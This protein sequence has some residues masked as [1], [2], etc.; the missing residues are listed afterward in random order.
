MT[1]QSNT[2]KVVQTSEHL[3]ILVAG[4]T[5][6]GFQGVDEFG[7]LH[8]FSFQELEEDG[9]KEDEDLGRRDISAEFS[10]QT[11]NGGAPHKI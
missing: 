1:K 10:D 6:V 9:G 2:P 4:L 5:P 3:R 7:K 8:H 11:D